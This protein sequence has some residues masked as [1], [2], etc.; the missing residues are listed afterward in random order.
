MTIVT[1]YAALGKEGLSHS[2]SETNTSAIFTSASL[3]QNIVDILPSLPHLHNIIYLGEAKEAL[4]RNFTKT[5]Q[6]KNIISYKDL[7][8]LGSNNLIEHTPPRPVDIACVMYTSGSTGP[9]KGVVITHQN[10]IASGKD[11]FTPFHPDKS[12]NLGKLLE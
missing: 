4:V 5:R 1:A 7:V 6:I 9:P 2:L 10:I 12:I 11:I 3:L 8:E